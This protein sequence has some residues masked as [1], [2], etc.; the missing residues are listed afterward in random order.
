MTIV[1]GLRSRGG[2]VAG[3]EDA[4]SGEGAS[5]GARLGDGAADVEGAL[6]GRDSAACA[7]PAA[8]RHP[9]PDI[10]TAS[11][12][13]PPIVRQQ[14]ARNDDVSMTSTTRRGPGS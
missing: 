10:A 5:D 13:T 4:G 7:Q 6:C 1:P 8:S 2:S 11:R 9:S 14:V 3:D 12:R